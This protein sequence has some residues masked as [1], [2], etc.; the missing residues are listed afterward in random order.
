MQKEYS[1]NSSVGNIYSPEYFDNFLIH[2]LT[3]RKMSATLSTSRK[4]S[5]SVVHDAE[6][7]N[8]QQQQQQVQSMGELLEVVQ[9]RMYN[10]EW[11]IHHDRQYN[12]QHRE[13]TDAWVDACTQAALRG[14]EYATPSSAFRSAP[15]A[16]PETLV[17]FLH[18]QC[19]QQLLDLNK[20]LVNI[21]LRNFHLRTDSAKPAMTLPMGECTITTAS[22]VTFDC[23]VKIGSALASPVHYM[24]DA[25]QSAARE[26]A[27]ASWCGDL[28]SAVLTAHSLNGVP[29]AASVEAHLACVA[30]TGADFQSRRNTNVSEA[31]FHAMH[32]EQREPTSSAELRRMR[33]EDRER[34]NETHVNDLVWSRMRHIMRIPDLHWMLLSNI[35]AC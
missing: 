18:Q 15:P 27:S 11:I 32:I 1:K 2:S 20:I 8:T 6:D 16:R 26:L 35:G 5:R 7:S 19:M 14:E 25:Y 10:L 12:T 33:Q 22:L 29:A 24:H 28:A 31:I 21:A 4:R 34:Y 30:V 23:F 17:T 9:E 3:H 13:E